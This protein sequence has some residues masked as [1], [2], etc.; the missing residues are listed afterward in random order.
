MKI[1][2]KIYKN[3]NLANEDIRGDN[4]IIDFIFSSAIGLSI[5]FLI[6]S[7]TLTAIIVFL[8]VRFTY[9]FCFEYFLDRTLGKFHTQSKVVDKNG[10]KPELTQIVFRSLGRNISLFS[11][12]SDDERAV[13]DQISNTF[14]IKDTRLSKIEFKNKLIFIFIFFY[15]GFRIFD[16]ETTNDFNLYGKVYRVMIQTMSTFVNDIF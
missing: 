15:A 1:T 9:Y 2:N 11:G 3:L 14:V 5:S 16:L 8:I 13:H 10:R 12:I 7:N 6:Y 4:F